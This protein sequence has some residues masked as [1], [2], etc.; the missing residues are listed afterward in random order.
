MQVQV[1][2]RIGFANWNITEK[3]FR[4]NFL[5]SPSA[6][7]DLVSL[8]CRAKVEAHFPMESSFIYFL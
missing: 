8:L 1:F 2:M 5:S 7:G 4:M 3:Y 6:K